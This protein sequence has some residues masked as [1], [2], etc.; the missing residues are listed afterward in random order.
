MLYNRLSCIFE[1]NIYL[2][3]I[4]YS[5]LILYNDK[6]RFQEI[7]NFNQILIFFEKIKKKLK[8]HIIVLEQ[9]QL[10]DIVLNVMNNFKIAI[11]AMGLLIVLNAKTQLIYI[12]ER[13]LGVL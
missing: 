4:F 7:V 1:L 12:I 6:R 3:L 2:F 9:L 10:E 8:K 11:N 5:K 13:V